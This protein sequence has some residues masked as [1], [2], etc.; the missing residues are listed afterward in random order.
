MTKRF[1]TEPDTPGDESELDSLLGKQLQQKI[2][3]L[4]ARIKELE[5]KIS[6]AVVDPAFRKAIDP[7]D[8]AW[9]KNEKSL[10][11]IA[12]TVPNPIIGLKKLLDEDKRFLDDD[13]S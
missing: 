4:E 13:A 2:S 7:D 8:V 9:I 11:R 3:L 1:D 12:G 5:A 10:G 6:V